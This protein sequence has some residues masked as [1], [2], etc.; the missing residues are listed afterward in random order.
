MRAQLR[1]RRTCYRG[2]VCAGLFTLCSAWW[3]AF[4]CLLLLQKGDAGDG[5]ANASRETTQA[6]D[7][8]RWEEDAIILAILSDRVDGIVVAV[9]SVARHAAA[10][11]S[12]HVILVAP[13]EIRS[14]VT[15]KLRS[16]VSSITGLSLAEAS[17]DLRQHGIRPMW[18]WDSY[19]VSAKD[20]ASWRTTSTIH[21]ASWDYLLTHIHPL[22]HLRFYLPQLTIFQEARSF[23]FLDDDVLI[24]K[25]L[26]MLLRRF[27]EA[28]DN[29]R[30]KPL[31]SMCSVWEWSQKCS[32]FEF[33][34]RKSRILESTVLYGRNVPICRHYTTSE[35]TEENYVEQ[36]NCVPQSYPSFLNSLPWSLNHNTQLSW[37]FGVSLFNVKAW[38]A[39]QM[40]QRY[41][42]MLRLNYRHRVFPETSLAFGLGVPYL[43]FAGEVACLEDLDFHVLDGLVSPSLSHW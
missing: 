37:N 15:Q 32:Q 1:I 21:V 40:T 31:L 33:L 43:A 20:F 36:K 35:M 23:F 14:V 3:C 22:N 25:D 34:D 39:K 28:N 30:Q 19:N 38:R 17:A 11:S 10:T 2:E 4:V 16:H 8:K 9:S 27:D 41:E 24:Q 42:N 5:I 7:T 6:S 29:I 26:G 12:I 13:L 18:E